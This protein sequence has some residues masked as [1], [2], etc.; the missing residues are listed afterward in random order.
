MVVDRL[1]LGWPPSERHFV[2]HTI[3]KRYGIEQMARVSV[4]YFNTEAEIERGQSHCGDGR[5]P[6]LRM[7]S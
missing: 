3:M 6:T 5:Q 7:Q 4:H 1:R 2:A